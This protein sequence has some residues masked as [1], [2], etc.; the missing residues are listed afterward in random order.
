M[1]ITGATMKKL[2]G[3]VC[4]VLGFAAS[5]SAASITGTLNFTGDVVVSATK[6]DFQDSEGVPNAFTLTPSTGYFSAMDTGVLTPGYGSSVDLGAPPIVG[7]LDD[8]KENPDVPSEYDDLSFNLQSI[9]APSVAAC[10]PNAHYAV[11]Q[12]C[13]LG[14]FTLVQTGTGVGIRM[15]ITGQFVDPTY[16]GGAVTDATGVYT[17]QR[18]GATIDA[19]LD[20]IVANPAITFRNSYSAQITAV[21]EPATLLTFGA[22]TALLAAHRR[23]RAKKNA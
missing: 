14:P 12:Q 9:V 1:S 6:I 2:V 20:A 22:G 18:A 13:A 19:M 15:D 5:A 16:M 7:F 17:A 23:R 4:L 21:P 8:F 11:N 10:D 3:I